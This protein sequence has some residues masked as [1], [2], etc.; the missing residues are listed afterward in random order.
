MIMNKCES[1]VLNRKAVVHGGALV[2][3]PF[4]ISLFEH[5]LYYTDWTKMAVMKANKFTDNSPQ[6]VYSAAQTPHGVA[7]IHQLKQPQGKS[8]CVEFRYGLYCF[9]G[10]AER[11]L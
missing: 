2:P 9:K 11:Y 3:H 10:G 7:V 8:H 1:S 4:S 5:T 6:V